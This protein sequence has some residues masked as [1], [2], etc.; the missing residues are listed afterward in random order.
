MKALDVL[1]VL[2][3]TDW[4]ENRSVLL[5][6]YRSLIRSKLDY[7]SIVYGSA[8]TSYLKS[9]DTIHQQVF[10]QNLTNHLYVQEGK[11]YRSNTP[12]S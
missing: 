8:R 3:D 7:G 11:N 9:L 10:M 12:R 2:S 4:G 6:Q 1:K 5:N